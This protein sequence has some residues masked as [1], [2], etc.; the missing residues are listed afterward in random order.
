MIVLV[1]FGQIEPNLLE[2]I[3]RSVTDTFDRTCHIAQAQPLPERAY[4]R[5][6]QQYLG[7]EFLKALAR[8]QVSEAERVLGVVDV[9]C[10]TPG[11]NFIFGQ[12]RMGGREAFIALPRLRES[13]Y[14]RPE[15]QALFQ[16]RAI[17]EAVHELGHTYGLEH[18]PDPRCVMHF[19]NSLADTDFKGQQFCDLCRKK[20]GQK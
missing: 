6:R 3:C 12:A 10:Y 1:P 9:D 18:C 13:F 5:R 17:K 14:R 16:E 2:V 19:S 15:N 20:L 8:L 11:L 4:D 7:Q